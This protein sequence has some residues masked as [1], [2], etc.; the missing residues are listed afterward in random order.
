MVWYVCHTLARAE[1][2]ADH[3]LRQAGYGTLYLHKA[4]TLRHARRAYDV[5]R[6]YFPRY[7]FFQT[8]P[9]GAAAGLYSASTAI[10]VSQVVGC[11][12]EPLEVP[13]RVMDELRR[14]AG[15]TGLIHAD[16][17]E[18]AH[19]HQ[20]GSQVRILAGP[21]EGFLALCRLDNG[22]E[23]RLWL[24]LFGRSTETTLATSSVESASP[25]CAAR[26]AM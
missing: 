1:A 25:E 17:F 26:R 11:A 7:V 10:G 21:F 18:E 8:A 24:N 4:V 22:R 19:L 6:P 2:I 23:I 20:P 12:G 5:L 9:S 14:R 13:A 15:P 16:T 3:Y